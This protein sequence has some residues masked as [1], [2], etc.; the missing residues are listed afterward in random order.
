MIKNATKFE[1]E[2]FYPHL[3]SGEIMAYE[4]TLTRVKDNNNVHAWAHNRLFMMQETSSFKK[5]F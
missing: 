1:V 4:L 3:Q 2:K 5:K